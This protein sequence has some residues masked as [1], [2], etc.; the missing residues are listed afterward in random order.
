MK[1]KKQVE[2]LSSSRN[3]GINRKQI[4]TVISYDLFFAFNIL[5]Y[6]NYFFKLLLITSIGLSQVPLL[7]FQFLHGKP[8]LFM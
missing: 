3:I 4:I 2:E 5:D 7:T 8:Y 6:V 1:W